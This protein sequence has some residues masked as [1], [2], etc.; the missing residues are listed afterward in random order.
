MTIGQG[1]AI[2]G[3]SIPFF[4]TVITAI[5]KYPFSNGENG[6]YVRRELCDERIKRL[7]KIEEGIEHTNATLMELLIEFKR[8]PKSKT[9]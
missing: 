7:E 2:A 3:I 4:G 5:I 6:K 9:Q 1:I 8:V